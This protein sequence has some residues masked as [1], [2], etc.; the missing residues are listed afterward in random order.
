MSTPNER[1]RP[2]LQVRTIVVGPDDDGTRLDKFFSMAFS[3]LS[4]MRIKRLI[5]ASMVTVANP[6]HPGDTLVTISE[7]SYRVKPG[8]TLELRIPPP[9]SAIPAAQEIP[10]IIVYED[11]QI[12]VIDKPAG[13][14]VH[15]AP[16]NP[17]RTLVNALLAHCGDSL[18]GIGGVRRPG[19]VHR[20]DKDTSGLMVAAK[21][22]R[23]HTGLAKQFACH[24][25]ERIYVALVWGL[26]RPPVGK[27]VGN[28]G[29]DSKHRTRMAV[30]EGRGK[31]AITHYRV[32]KSLES[33]ASVVECRLETGRT[34]QIRVHLATLGHAV[35]G[36]PLYGGRR[37]RKGLQNDG[38]QALSAFNR[39]A[40]HAGILGFDHPVSG[41]RLNFKSELPSEFL[42]LISSF[43]LH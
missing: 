36:D 9:E 40:L 13:L 24:S 2:V 7:P 14:V 3:D 6:D 30:V 8:L 28:I 31:P 26:P 15:P 33:T 25:I 17:D 39:Q 43:E 4:R 18:S 11:D 23:A 5:Q 42:H 35:V 22:D 29:R 27:I 34:H 1:S 32:R 38:I 20:L 10:L 21:S 37:P 19:I 41:K 16:G 12:V